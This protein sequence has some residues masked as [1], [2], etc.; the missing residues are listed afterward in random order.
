VCQ[1]CCVGTVEVRELIHVGITSVDQAILT[2]DLLCWYEKQGMPTTPQLVRYRCLC[3]RILICGVCRARFINIT[4]EAA[5][6]G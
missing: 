4:T 2:F 5:L 6:Q 1:G 3:N